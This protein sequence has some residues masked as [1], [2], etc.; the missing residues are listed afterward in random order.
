MF[1][2]LCLILHRIYVYSCI[3][4]VIYGFKGDLIYIYVYIYIYVSTYILIYYLSVGSLP[5]TVLWTRCI[6][7]NIHIMT[8][9]HL[10]IIIHKYMNKF[11]LSYTYTW[12]H[13]QELQNLHSETMI[14]RRFVSPVLSYLSVRGLPSTV[15]CTTGLFIWHLWFQ[16]GR[17][18]RAGN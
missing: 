11:L 1:I 7:V 9:A 15:L 18:R 2:N 16:M 5:L 8:L 14:Q 3:Y 4:M 13:K 17:R 6:Y 12:L 10:F